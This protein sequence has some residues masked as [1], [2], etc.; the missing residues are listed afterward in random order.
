MN[1]S[2]VTVESWI[3]GPQYSISFFFFLIWICMFDC[4]Y[5][6]YVETESVLRKI[7]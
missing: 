4:V 3:D 7:V 1:C 5:L 2:W 6:S